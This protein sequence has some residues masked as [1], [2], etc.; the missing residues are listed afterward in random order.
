M[1]RLALPE[2]PRSIPE[3]QAAA[4]VGQSALMWHYEAGVQASRHRGGPGAADRPGHQRSR[5]LSER[6]Q[7]AARPARLRRPADR[8]RERHGGRRRDQGRRQRQPHRAGRLAHRRRSARA[9]H[10]RGRAV[11]GD[12]RRE[13]QAAHLLETVEAVTDEIHGPGVRRVPAA[14]SVGGMATKLQAAQK[15]GAAGIPMVIASGRER[16]VRWPGCSRARRWGPTSRPGTTGSA[17]ASAGSPSRF[18]PQ[19]RLMVDAGAV[20][21]P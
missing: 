14:V 2:R 5:A 1:A 20:R 10:R 12:P 15:A 7:H 4:A 13:P 16:G 21:R 11:H 9:A 6:A 8:Q 19:G 18:R 17:P 3:K